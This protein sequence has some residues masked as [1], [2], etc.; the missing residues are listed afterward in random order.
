MIGTY[1]PATDTEQEM[2]DRGCTSQG[3]VFKD[4]DAYEQSL[5]K[6]C[7]I[8]E[9]SDTKYTHQDFL[10]MC[11]GQEE[12]ARFIFN[13]VDWQS[14]ETEVEESFA[15]DEIKVCEECGKW[16]LSYGDGDY[17]CPHCKLER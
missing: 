2:I 15:S 3:F 8:P 6:V 5:G 1:K 4:E 10:D 11:N 13:T 7:Y 12:I 9:L 14:P 16:H 17:E